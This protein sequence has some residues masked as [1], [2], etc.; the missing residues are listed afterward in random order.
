VVPPLEHS[1][2]G[3]DVGPNTVK[4]IVP[5][6]SLIAPDRLELIELAVIALPA[7]P[8]P[9]ADTPVLVAASV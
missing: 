5:V 1:L 6:A 8:L 3:V 2:G 4:V 9:G 7:V